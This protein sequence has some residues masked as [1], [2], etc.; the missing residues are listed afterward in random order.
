MKVL[1][2]V[3][4]MIVTA[5]NVNGQSLNLIPYPKNVKQLSGFYVLNKGVRLVTEKKEFGSLL[6]YFNAELAKRNKADKKQPLKI[7]LKQTPG[8]IS[9]SYTLATDSRSIQI[10]GADKAGLFNGL[11]TLL[12]LC[13]SANPDYTSIKIPRLIIKDEPRFNWRGVMLDE[14]RHFFGAETVKRILDWMAFYKLNKFHWH[15]TDANGWR[16]EIKKYPLLTSIGGRGNFTDSLAAAKFYTQGEIRD[17]VAYASARNISIIPEID[18]P[19]HA[20]A[21]NRAYPEFSGG[22]ISENPDFTFD[23]AFEGTYTY[24][25]NILTEVASLFPGKTIHLGGDEVTLGI[26]AWKTNPRIQN[27]MK[28]KKFTDFVDLEHYFLKRMT[29]SAGKRGLRVIC[30]DEAVNANLPNDK[31]YIQWWRHNKPDSFTEAISKGY[32]VILSPRLPLYFDFVQDPA[33]QSGRKWGELY[34][35]YLAIYRYPKNSEIHKNVLGVQA[36][37]WTETIATDKRLEFLLFPRIAALAESGWTA[38]EAKNEAKFNTR[39][40]SHIALYKNNGIYFYNPFS[41]K[42]QPEKI[43]FGK[44]KEII[45]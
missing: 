35:S 19:G 34:N 12:Q 40:K 22:K 33:H 32:Q 13:L 29:D 1:L 41:P 15:L 6:E 25:S 37:I 10:T 23:P 27:I 36:N 18:M 17:I 20:S 9:G 30:W 28:E 44:G 16:L 38:P 39:L 43:D 31:V 24:L 45:D 4:L 21:S 2:L 11:S 8:G 5:I 3:F 42:E 7:L 14:S 26:D